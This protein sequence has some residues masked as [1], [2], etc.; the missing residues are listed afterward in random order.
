[1]A[2]ADKNHAFILGNLLKRASELGSSFEEKFDSR[3]QR[4][5]RDPKL[6]AFLASS[7]NYVSSSRLE[8]A[9]FEDELAAIRTRSLR[10][11]SLESWSSARKAAMTEREPMP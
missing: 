3:F 4:I 2:N 11:W 10:A 1:M 6:L 7:M 8:L 5:A 9:K